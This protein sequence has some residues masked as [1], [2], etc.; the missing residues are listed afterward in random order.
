MSQALAALAWVVASY[1]GGIT[2]ALTL[3]GWLRRQDRRE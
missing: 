2:L 3:E 1:A